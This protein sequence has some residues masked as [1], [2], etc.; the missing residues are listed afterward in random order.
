[1]DF[2]RSNRPGIRLR[3]RFPRGRTGKNTGE[4]YTPKIRR[5][6]GAILGTAGNTLSLDVESTGTE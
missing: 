6:G 3:A 1:M 4:V 5:E 2:R